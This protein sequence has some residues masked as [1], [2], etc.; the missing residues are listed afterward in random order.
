MRPALLRNFALALT[1]FTIAVLLGHLWVAYPLI[2]SGVVACL[3][4]AVLGVMAFGL[5]CLFAML[6]A[7]KGAL[8]GR[9]MVPIALSMPLVVFA[10]FLMATAI[11]VWVVGG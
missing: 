9:G 6:K 4:L 8:L 3:G 2:R 1:G 7:S 10:G 11:G 5:F